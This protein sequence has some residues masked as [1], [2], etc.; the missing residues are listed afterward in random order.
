MTHSYFWGLIAGLV[1]LMVF[2]RRAHALGAKADIG[3]GGH[4]FLAGGSGVGALKLL[5][6][7][8]WMAFDET[9]MCKVVND[10]PLSVH[11]ED[12]I[13][14]GL[15]GIVLGWVSFEQLKEK[16]LQLKAASV[17]AN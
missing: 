16:F 15:G 8:L 3:S 11:G 17:P 6:F 2:L 9:G 10:T 14:I 4:V 1:A 12:A 7:A 13:F 5:I